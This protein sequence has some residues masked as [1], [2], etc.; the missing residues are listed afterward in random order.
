MSRRRGVRTG[1]PTPREAP[2]G[3]RL[4]RAT[5]EPSE[6]RGTTVPSTVSTLAMSSSVGYSIAFLDEGETGYRQP[7]TGR[8]HLR[9]LPA[10]SRALA[11]HELCP[12]VVG[13]GFLVSARPWGLLV[14]AEQPIELLSEG[15]ETP[16]RRDRR[17]RV[18]WGAVAR[19]GDIVIAPL[20]GERLE[21]ARLDGLRGV[22]H[23]SAVASP[24]TRLTTPWRPVAVAIAALVAAI[25][26]LWA[27]AVELNDSL[28]REL[29]PTASSV[30]A[31]ATIDATGAQTAIPDRGW[32]S[33]G[34]MFDICP[35]AM[36]QTGHITLSSG[37]Y[38]NRCLSRL[39]TLRERGRFD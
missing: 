25:A 24:R 31:P 18:P 14:Q 15:A 9:P 2:P 29:L 20:H 22:L 37:A 17:V 8:W 27:T 5:P 33:G 21:A 1:P 13:R 32:E 23:A 7:G 38:P 26:L 6:A 36:L 11:A 10:T 35:R 3:R 39:S 19:I 12:F 30:S 34:A 4:V 16:A 28:G